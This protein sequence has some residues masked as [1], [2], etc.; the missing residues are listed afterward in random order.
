[1]NTLDR[2]TKRT[3]LLDAAMAVFVRKGFART[4][5][6]DIAT[7]A[8]VGKGTVYEYFASK[9]AL[10]FAVFERIQED[11]AS[12]LKP[13]LSEIG[14]SRE[15]LQRLFSKGAEITRRQVENQAVVL[16]FWAASR[17]NLLEEQ[18]RDF[19]VSGF[20]FYRSLVAQILID[21]Q[22]SGE[23]NPNHDPEGLAVMIVAAF[24]GLGAQLYLDR[25]VDVERAVA[26]FTNTLCDALCLEDE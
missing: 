14:T 8:D 21:G 4:R 25:S 23:L 11:I 13:E 9:E 26:A 3:T 18:F 7:E 2:E 17:G 22:T 24:D 12:E 6:A 10:F 19:C 20:A 16:D 15:R 1:M 5:V